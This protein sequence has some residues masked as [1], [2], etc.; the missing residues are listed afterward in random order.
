MDEVSKLINTYLPDEMRGPFEYNINKCN[1]I[2]R[3]NKIPNLE[4][5]CLGEMINGV[6]K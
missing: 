2:T 5:M 3:N 4:Y 1:H 6:F